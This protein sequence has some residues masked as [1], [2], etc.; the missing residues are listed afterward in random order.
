MGFPALSTK[1]RRRSIITLSLTLSLFAISG[2]LLA[3][4]LRDMDWKL[5]C[6]T[7]SDRLA[8]VLGL[9]MLGTLA[10]TLLVYILVR[11][12][13]Y[14]TT[15]WKSYLV[16]TAS[17]SANYVTPVKVG[18]PLRIYL[19]SHFMDVPISIGTALVAVEALVGILTSAC[20]AVIGIVLLFPTLGLTV[21]VTL[22]ALL[23]TGS[24]FL[25][26]ARTERLQPYLERL[27]FSRFT[28]WAIRFAERVQ[29]SL[30][31]LSPA[32][33]LGVM[34]LDLLILGLQAIRLWLVL[35]V[36]GPPPSVL[37][38]LAVLTIS[39]TAGNLSMIPMGLGVRDASFTVLL[40]QLGVPNEI[41]LSV[42]V[43]QRLF[44][45]GWPLLL[46]LISTNVLG[47]GEI[48]RAPGKSFP[49]GEEKE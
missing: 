18:I 49:T 20:I 23:A 37:A 7:S 4:L 25:L 38:L 27:P 42:A 32:A 11:A 14:V 46:G 43:I 6:Q 36:F 26:L 2:I 5:I 22:I 31:C 45:P 1:G 39:V 35:S 41:A 16:L 44:S 28:T 33:V 30:R 17:L 12:G 47:L 24:L 40:A 15:L 19:Y 3:F 34:F 29:L 8:L 21:P 48:L 10:Y 9:T 13:G